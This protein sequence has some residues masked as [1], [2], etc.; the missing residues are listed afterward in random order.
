M[1]KFSLKPLGDSCMKTLCKSWLFI[2]LLMAFCLA[3]C[4]DDDDNAVTPIFPEK[5]N[6]ICNSNDTREFTFTANTNWSLASSAIWCKFKTDDEL[7]EFV[8]SGTAGTQ[9][10]TL[11]ITNDNMQVGDVSVAK[12][13][14]TMGGQTIVIGEVTRSKVDY[15]LKIYDK[16]GND[17][18]KDGVL[19]VGYQEY[20]LFDVE[21]NF[22]FAATNL[23]GWVELDGGS[24]V[25]PVNKKVQGGLRIIE[26][27]IR[28]KYPV[29]ASDENVITFSDEEGRAFHSIKLVYEGMTPGVMELKRPSSNMYD[30]VVSLDGKSFTQGSGGVAGTGSS[31]TSFKNRLPFTVKTLEDKY[32]VVFV[33]KGASNNNLYF[34]GVDDDEWMDEKWM[35]CEDEKKDGN[36]SLIVKPFTPISGYAEERVGYVLVFSDAEFNR[37]G[38]DNLE[39]TIINGDELVY[40]YEQTNL[41]LQF[42]QKEIKKDEA[43]Q[44]FSA[45][46][47]TDYVTPIECTPYTE[48]NAEHFKTEYGV[49]GISEI[50]QP[51]VSTYVTVSFE[52]WD[53]KCYFLDNEEAA[54]DGIIDPAGTT[55]SIDSK[56]TNGKDI[57]VIVKGETEDDKAMLIV[58]TSNASGGEVG[59]E[60]TAIFKITSSN[61]MGSDFVCNPYSGSLGGAQYF[62]NTYG[63]TELFEMEN[64]NAGI[65][66]ALTSS[67]VVSYK[68][69]T[70]TDTSEEELTSDDITI[71]EDYFSGKKVLNV[72]LGSGSSLP[73]SSKPILLVITGEDGSK[74]ILFIINK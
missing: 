36:I 41:V 42:T 13:E 1:K 14:L 40:Q 31:T 8:L 53:A 62:Q 24:L 46:D 5:Q 37:I 65:N 47:G 61:G 55:M 12:L 57:F 3:A 71:G 70:V 19:K 6:L 59:G 52:I 73:I 18:T 34:E 38:R 17:I 26:N 28:E 68:A 21:A 45:V 32:H 11:V 63:A 60:E 54:P 64:P 67:D 43:I 66:I 10:V 30:W 39:S 69:Y 2:G 25:G 74:Q 22:R 35:S 20:V 9:T 16:E 4:S 15:E 50:K 56:K 27:G 49:K 44:Y 7:G 29:L 58:R 33:T 72:W 23:P 48:S 51:G